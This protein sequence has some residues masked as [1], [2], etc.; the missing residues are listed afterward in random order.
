MPNHELTINL[1]IGISLF[2]EDGTDA[3]TIIKNADSA[4]YCA[5]KKGRNQY[6]LFASGDPQCESACNNDPPL[7]EIGVQ[8]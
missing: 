7:A 4:M 8:N 3:D 5:K 1:S 6:H 2:P